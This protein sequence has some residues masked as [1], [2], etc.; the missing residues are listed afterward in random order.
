MDE[1]KFA[2]ITIEHEGS[3]DIVLENVTQCAIVAVCW[4]G[5]IKPMDRS[6]FMGD[7]FTLAGRVSELLKRFDFLIQQA[8]VAEVLKQVS[9]QQQLQQQIQGLNLKRDGKIVN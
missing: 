2:K 7:P 1:Q 4:E 8:A 6:H 3:E 5:G 9:Q